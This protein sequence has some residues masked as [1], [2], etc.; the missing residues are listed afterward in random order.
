MVDSIN[1][2]LRLKIPTL[3][4][5]EFLTI[6]L[7]NHL[8]KPIMIAENKYEKLRKTTKIKSYTYRTPL[9]STVS[10][11][12]RSVVFMYIVVFAWHNWDK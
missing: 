8:T 12:T 10:K 7:I 6:E 9:K 1:V 4:Q 3:R 11:T 5:H 2:H